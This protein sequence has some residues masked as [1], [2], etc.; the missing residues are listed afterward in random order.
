LTYAGRRHRG[1]REFSRALLGDELQLNV[2]QAAAEILPATSWSPAMPRWARCCWSAPACGPYAAALRERL[3]LP[4]FDSVSLITRSYG[5][6]VPRR[7][8]A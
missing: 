1:G 4:V 6:L 5:C 8:P 7:W 2:A 3:G